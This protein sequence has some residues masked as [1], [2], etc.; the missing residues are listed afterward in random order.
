MSHFFFFFYQH[1]AFIC[2]CVDPIET[3]KIIFNGREQ[4]LF[5]IKII[6]MD[7]EEENDY[8]FYKYTYMSDGES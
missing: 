8:G 4:K 2:V 5:I 3:E 1:L 7:V 6:S